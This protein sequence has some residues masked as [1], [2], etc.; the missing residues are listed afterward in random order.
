MS[1][2]ILKIYSTGGAWANTLDH[3]ISGEILNY[4][5][6]DNCNFLI[7]TASFL[8][9]NSSHQYEDDITVDDS[10]STQVWRAHAM[11]GTL[12]NS[13]V[14]TSVEKVGS[15]LL[16]KGKGMSELFARKIIES[17]SFYSKDGAG[18]AM[19]GKYIL[20]DTTYGLV[21]KYLST[22]YGAINVLASGSGGYVDTPLTTQT[23][24][25]KIDGITL[26]D[27][28]IL[29]AK[30]SYGRTGQATDN[31]YDVYLFETYSAGSYSL[32]FWFREREIYPTSGIL[33]FGPSDIYM[34]DLKYAPSVLGKYN[35]VFVRGA[36]DPTS[37]YPKDITDWTTNTTNWSISKEEGGDAPTIGLTTTNPYLGA[38]ALE[39]YRGSVTSRTMYY[40]DPSATIIDNRYNKIKF[41]AIASSFDD[42]DPSL[43]ERLEFKLTLNIKDKYGNKGDDGSDMAYNSWH[44]YYD[45]S[46]GAISTHLSLNE[47]LY[48]FYDI[49][50][51]SPGLANGWDNALNTFHAS[52]ISISEWDTI[53]QLGFRIDD[54]A[55]EEIQYMDISGLHFV[56]NI[57]YSGSATS[58]A[59]TYLK[60]YIYTDRGL[61]SDTICENM[62]KQLLRAFKNTQYPAEISLLG[63]NRNFSLMAGENIEL[64]ILEKGINVISGQTPAKLPIQSITYTPGRQHIK[65][66]RHVSLAEI[67]NDA[68]RSIKGIDKIQ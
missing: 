4:T 21:G 6:V 66:G 30:A 55:G 10:S 60:E 26:W 48:T 31:V 63:Y 67:I 18:N 49:P 22:T 57:P 47:A 59:P 27:A 7:D 52:G 19:H 16:V 29:V 58:G 50:L 35:K 14:I 5:I 36:Y 32:N 54:D 28:C 2:I 40:Y 61:H 12:I 65:A 42:L 62:A 25:N 8:I 41:W 17:E 56:G 38:S 68:R 43:F 11:D 45:L 23:L 51:P 24:Q 15:N 64:Q 37:T 53:Y 9:D 13:G 34:P 1:D 33:R 44:I 20:T 3:E 39:F 46:I